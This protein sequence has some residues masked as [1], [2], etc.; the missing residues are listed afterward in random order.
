MTLKDWIR[1]KALSFLGLTQYDLGSDDKLTFVNDREAI[2]REKIREYNV[3]YSGD[4]DNLLNYY[5]QNNLIEYNYEPFFDRNKK[6]YFWAINSTENDIK[7]THSGQPR[8]IVDTMVSI[9]GVPSVRGGTNED[10]NDLLK[11]IIDDNNFW[12]MYQQEQLPMTMVEGW[13]AY[14]INW[15]LDL[16]D[17]PII[18]YYRAADVDFIYKSNR[19][20]GI[21]FKDYY[22]DKKDHKYLITE[23]RRIE[24][25]N[26]II[27]KELFSVTEVGKADSQLKPIPFSEVP[28]LASN[29]GNERLVIND[30]K[31]LLAVPCKFYHDTQ[32]G[33][34]GRSIFTGKIDLFDDLDQCLSQS[35]NTV[36]KSTPMEYFNSDFLE[37]DRKT[38]MPIQPKA[39]DRKYTMY[40]GGKDANGNTNT[41]Q[42]V[43]VTQ[44]QLNFQEYSAEA[45]AILLQCINGIIS[46]ATLGIDI[47]KK[48]NAE[49]QRE[50]EKVTIFTRNVML[51]AET[52]VLEKLF[53][54]CLCAYELMH[55]GVITVK[56]YDI[57][58]KFSEFADASFESKL[59]SLIPAMQTQIMSPRMFVTKLYGESLDEKDFE[60][61]VKYIEDQLEADKEPDMEEEAG[62]LDLLKEDKELGDDDE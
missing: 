61:E 31:S 38:G 18:M 39:Y 51:Q 30:F 42:P 19:L 49:A 43:I 6:C 53:S 26:L 28:E 13:G 37:R 29:V 17:Y 58:I 12:W 33:A 1:N 14:K 8:N 41:N 48:D 15:D 27:E 44:P 57:S 62:M 2:T 20:I 50:K 5:T 7:R 16:S 54:Q 45:Q 40:S 10:T 47:A 25:G 24:H 3:W 34:Y 36:R 9:I 23:T 46:P 35:A 55:K 56:N 4:G 52:T 60:T 11:E 59:G 22:K 32:Y 21:I